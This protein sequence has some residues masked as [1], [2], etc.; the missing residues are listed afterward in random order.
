M[1]KLI[2]VIAAIVALGLALKNLPIQ[3][4]F[5]ASRSWIDALG[6]W[7]PAA[8]V[9]AY[10]LLTIAM[11]PG[12]ALTLGSGLI[13]GLWKGV[14]V[15]ILGANIGALGAFF[16]A[17]TV[18]RSRA[19]HLAGQNP[20]FKVIDAA[21]GREGFKLMLL[22]RLSPAFP[23]TILNMLAGLTRITPGAYVSANLLGMLPG[24]FMYVYLGTLGEAATGAASTSQLA[25]KLVGLV[26]T[27]VVTVVLTKIAK[28][29]LEEIQVPAVVGKPQ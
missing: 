27:I 18:L 2:A 21:I 17:R 15:A 14:V 4:W 20:K 19:E 11:I 12:S 7:G 23:F 16:L 25:L 3:E 26:A 22:L 6:F 13:F 8:V 9:L 29:S 24:T 28:R 1:K 10:A 5:L